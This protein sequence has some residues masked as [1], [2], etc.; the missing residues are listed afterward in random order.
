MSESRM[1]QV[2]VRELRQ[3]GA[4]P[5]ENP[6]YPGTPDVNYIGGW[7]ELKWINKWP[8]HEA[9]RVPVPHFT[10]QQKVWLTKRQRLGGRTFLLLQC[11]NEWL[12]F[13]GITATKVIH[14]AT[15]QELINDTLLYMP[16]GLVTEELITCLTVP[17]R[18]TLNQST[19]CN[20][21]ANNGC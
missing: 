15:R 21:G 16:K 5:V 9:S 19:F 18:S 7:I 2:V 11:K 17:F 12:L 14:V 8:V 1:R 4:L 13:D 10:P 6:V 3:L 20:D